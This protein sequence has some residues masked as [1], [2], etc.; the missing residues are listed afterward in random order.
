MK[1]GVAGE[2]CEMAR[3]IDNERGVFKWQR[4]LPD[5]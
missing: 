1:G 2:L 4:W 5:E 3:G